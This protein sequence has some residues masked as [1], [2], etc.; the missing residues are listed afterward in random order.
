MPR[1]LLEWQTIL[2]YKN[3][4]FKFYEIGERLYFKKGK[5]ITRKETS[6]SE[7]KEKYGSENYPK[8]YFKI[9]I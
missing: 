3:K 6:I 7:F 8:A 2:H 4:L 5:K 1:H 9:K